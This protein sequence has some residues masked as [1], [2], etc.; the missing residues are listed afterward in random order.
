MSLI[1]IVD[2]DADIRA[3]LAM[4]L[5]TRGYQS[6]QAANGHEAL[7]KLQAG[8]RPS[9]VLVDLMMPG[10]NG[11]ELVAAVGKDPAL[12]SIPLVVLTGYR[13]MVGDKAFPGTV[14][15][16][17]KPVDLKQLFSLLERHP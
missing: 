15:V 7:E 8:L 14:G 11:W 13:S 16:L 4:V 9:L 12:A 10:M 1:L 3:A 2:D 17:T 6:M 5:H